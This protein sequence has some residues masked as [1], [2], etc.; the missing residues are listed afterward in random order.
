MLGNQIGIGVL[1]TCVYAY[2]I[3]SCVH[4]D[5]CFVLMYICVYTM[6]PHYMWP[7]MM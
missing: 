6:Y 2:V 3:Y 4:K 1:S 7:T 5:A